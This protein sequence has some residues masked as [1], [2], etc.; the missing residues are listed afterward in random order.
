MT[1][2]T[3]A[4]NLICWRGRDEDLALESLTTSCGDTTC[5][6]C[7]ENCCDNNQ[8]CYRDVDWHFGASLSSKQRQGNDDEDEN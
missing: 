4:A 1:V 8:D 2:G 5:S 7:I 6:C 3:N